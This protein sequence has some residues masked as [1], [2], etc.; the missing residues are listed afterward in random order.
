[1][2]K[3]KVIKWLKELEQYSK[4]NGYYGAKKIGEARSV[5]YEIDGLTGSFCKVT[6]WA[7]GE[8]Y[9]IGFQ[10]K[11]GEAWEDK[12]I[13]LHVDELECLITALNDLKFFGE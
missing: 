9:D 7:N 11:S 2:G 6:E 1:M 5:E 3:K 8:G 4:D 10:S 12:R 13:S